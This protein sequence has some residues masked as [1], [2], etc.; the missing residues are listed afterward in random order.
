[1]ILYEQSLRQSFCRAPILQDH[2]TWS[3]Y[4]VHICSY[5]FKYFHINT[6]TSNNH[7]P[8]HKPS[9]WSRSSISGCL[10]PQLPL[11]CSISVKKVPGR[12][13]CS[14]RMNTTWAVC[15]GMFKAI[16]GQ[17]L[18]HPFCRYIRGRYRSIP[19]MHFCTTKKQQTTS[20][21]YGGHLLEEG[22]KRS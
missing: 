16:K 20:K 13:E 14:T 3:R 12:T 10:K 9:N 21:T 1:M 17:I 18:E 6:P 4:Y 2:K 22:K 15:E 5:T 7:L 19:S 11:G 8:R